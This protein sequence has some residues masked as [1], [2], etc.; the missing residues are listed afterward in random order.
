MRL[1]RFRASPIHSHAIVEGHLHLYVLGLQS[2]DELEPE[3]Y[4]R[5]MLTTDLDPEDL[6]RL[7][8]GHMGSYAAI[9]AT[10]GPSFQQW[11]LRRPVTLTGGAGKV[12]QSYLPELVRLSGA[13]ETARREG[14]YSHHDVLRLHGLYF[15][16]QKEAR[17]C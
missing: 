5:S 16:P 15:A 8:S 6:A 9:R 12:V 2:G 13:I 7:R 10:A 3:V 1:L 4:L 11:P 17:S 14:L